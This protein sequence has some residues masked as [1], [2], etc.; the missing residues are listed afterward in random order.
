MTEAEQQIL[1]WAVGRIGGSH[2][3]P[4]GSATAQGPAGRPQKNR[5]RGPLLKSELLLGGLV[6]GRPGVQAGAWLTVRHAKMKE[7]GNRRELDY[8][9]AAHLGCEN[10]ACAQHLT[11]RPFRT[12]ANKLCVH[13]PLP[14]P[15]TAQ[16]YGSQEVSDPELHCLASRRS[17]CS[18]K[19]QR[20]R[21]SR[22]ATAPN[23]RL[24]FDL[25]CS[26]Q[27]VADTQ[28]LAASCASCARAARAQGPRA[29]K[30]AM[31]SYGRPS[32]L[33]TQVAMSWHRL[34]T[35]FARRFYSKTLN[36]NSTLISLQP[37]SAILEKTL[38]ATSTQV[39][40]LHG[41]LF[42]ESWVRGL[43]QTVSSSGKERLW[44]WLNSF[45]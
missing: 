34:L 41:I 24:P 11:L 44:A 33:L 30:P 13:P 29:L 8:S 42:K 37:V 21:G 12:R 3:P 43:R 31:Y 22:P 20:Q 5:K 2:A 27:R 32:L 23:A 4:S 7:G 6:T 18:Q 28:A 14:A 36:A 17:H 26:L 38:N 16:S 1:N 35:C 40:K 15:L 39:D 45:E 25:R 19:K 9:R 10:V